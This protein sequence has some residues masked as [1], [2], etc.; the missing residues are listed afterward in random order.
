MPEFHL[1]PSKL[2]VLPELDRNTGIRDFSTGV[3]ARTRTSLTFCQPNCHTVKSESQSRL[4]RVR[5]SVKIDDLRGAKAEVQLRN[6]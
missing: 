2:F 6:R 3:T 5:G 1:S 4:H